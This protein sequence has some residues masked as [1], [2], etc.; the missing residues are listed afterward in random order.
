[1]VQASALGVGQGWWEQ[2]RH[3]GSPWLALEGQA[4]VPVSPLLWSQFFSWWLSPGR[5]VRVIL[6]VSSPVQANQLGPECRLLPEEPTL[7]KKLLFRPAVFP[8]VTQ[9]M[10]LSST[11]LFHFLYSVFSLRA[12]R[13][14]NTLLSG[15]TFR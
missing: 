13:N 7:S 2:S 8:R 11:A 4:W 14:E 5:A 6:I 9:T 15:N 12:L 3:A 1:M 10:V